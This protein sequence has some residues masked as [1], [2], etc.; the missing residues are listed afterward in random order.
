MVYRNLR[1]IREYLGL[2]STQ[3]AS[4]LKMNAFL[5]RKYEEGAMEPAIDL[6]L[7]L[8]AAYA[9]P[10]DSLVSKDVDSSW[11]E[12]EPGIR[13]LSDLSTEDRLL[14]MQKNICVHCLAPCKKINYR[15][16]SDFCNQKRRI[17]SERIKLFRENKG[18]DASAAAEIIQLN[19][20]DYLSL[21]KG[22]YPP[23]VSQIV[24]IANY[25]GEEIRSFLE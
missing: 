13:A 20:D 23:L 3:V 2:T 9:I 16:L 1:F 6:L 4:Q 22:I 8:S 10:I 19:T 12:K 24:A 7:L 17:L 11:L 18:L 25:Y 5:Y 14:T 21:E 15:I